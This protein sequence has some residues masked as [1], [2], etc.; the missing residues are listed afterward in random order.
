MLL[1]IVK[2]RPP[3][4][5]VFPVIATLELSMSFATE[6]VI[7]NAL[8]SHDTSVLGNVVAI[9]DA[10]MFTPGCGLL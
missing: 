3:L 1:N 7:P 9:Y 4:L 2:D 8:V 6:L 10:V 5:S